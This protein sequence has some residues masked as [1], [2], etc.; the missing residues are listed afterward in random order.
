MIGGWGELTEFPA[1]VAVSAVYVVEHGLGSIGA[2]E[3]GIELDAI[4]RRAAFN[5]YGVED[6][7]PRVARLR[8]YGIEVEARLCRFG[9]KVSASALDAGEAEAGAHD[10]GL[11]LMD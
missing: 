7:G 2:I 6:G 8:G 10:N 9:L 4:V 11:I 3:V 5:F 1:C